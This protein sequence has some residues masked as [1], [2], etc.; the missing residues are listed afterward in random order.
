MQAL[1]MEADSVQPS[2]TRCR[3]MFHFASLL[4]EMNVYLQGTAPTR[5]S[6]ELA[7]AN[8]PKVIY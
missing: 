3:R 8:V 6:E 2:I 4:V 1:L 7:L 5:P